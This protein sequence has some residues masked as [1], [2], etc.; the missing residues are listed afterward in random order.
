MT[1]DVYTLA[2]IVAAS[3]A[4]GFVV[5]VGVVVGTTVRFL[6]YQAEQK[7]RAAGRG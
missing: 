2:G 4:F 7:K 5:G 3:T 1:V 6:R